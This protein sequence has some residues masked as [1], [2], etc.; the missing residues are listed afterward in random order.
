MARDPARPRA[1]DLAEMI[2]RLGDLPL[3]AEPGTV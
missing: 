3:M 2:E 1:R